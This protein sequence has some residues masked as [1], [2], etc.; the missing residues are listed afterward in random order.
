MTTILLVHG[1]WATAAVWQPVIEPLE[2]LGFTVIAPTLP[3]QIDGQDP[4][5][6][7]LDVYVQFLA[8][9]IQAIDEPVTVLGHSGGGMVISQLA[10]FCPKKVA[11]LIYLAGMLLPSGTNFSEFCQQVL[12]EGGSRVGASGVNYIDQTSACSILQTEQLKTILFNCTPEDIANQAIA[13]LVP[14]PIGGFYLLNTLTQHAFGSVEK[15]YIRLA[16][17]KTILPAVQDEM[18]KLT[19]VASVSEIDTDHFPQLSAPEQIISTL[20]LICLA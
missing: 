12:G 10:E 4:R 14:Q 11:K 5:S 16:Q 15:H 9:I 2:Q 3:G 13:Q 17:D 20:K 18:V 8:D 7:N 6:I 1:A 19:T